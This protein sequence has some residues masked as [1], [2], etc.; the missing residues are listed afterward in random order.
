MAVAACAL[1]GCSPAAAPAVPFLGAYFPSWLLSSFAG[2]AAALVVRAI[3]V[4]IGLDDVLPMRL[5][6]Y[7]SLAA[8][9]GFLVSIA[10]FGR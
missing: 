2:I 6:V 4:R 8:A 5:L 7:L 3:F 9:V 1:A 10:V